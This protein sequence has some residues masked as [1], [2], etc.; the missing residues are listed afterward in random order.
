MKE[1]FDSKFQEETIILTFDCSKLL[2]AGET[3]DSAE[4]AVSVIAGTDANPGA[5]LSGAVAISG[6]NVSHK[7]LGGIEGAS[8]R[9]KAKVTTSLVQ[10]LVLVADLDVVPL[11]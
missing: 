1:K 7:I 5:M 2:A 6:S 11:S 3:I 8:Y 9:M 4:W 10:I